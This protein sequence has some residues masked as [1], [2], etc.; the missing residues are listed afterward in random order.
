MNL[1]G[2]Y[3]NEAGQTDLAIAYLTTMVKGAKNEAIKVTLATRLRALEGVRA[4]E[5]ARNACLKATGRLPASVEAL[6]QSGY[7]K[8]IPLDPYGGRFYLEPDGKVATTSKFA[9]PGTA[10]KK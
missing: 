1:A 10:Q 7:L 6:Q 2:R 3:L 8:K 5:G 9:S 4:I